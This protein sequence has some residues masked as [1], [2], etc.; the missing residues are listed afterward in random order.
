MPGGRRWVVACS[1]VVCIVA[2]GCSDP[3]RVILAGLSESDQAR[4][5]D[6]RQIAV[7]CWT[8]HDLAGVVK[9]VGPSLQGVYGRRSGLA[10][11]HGGS[12]AMISASIVWD[13][14][15]LAAF[16]RDPAGFVPGNR[17]V[18]PGIRDV[19][20]LSDLLFYLRHVSHPGARGM[21][22]SH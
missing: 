8:C 1:L 9:K 21:S 16:L 14:R 22:A 2:G 18:S 20:S 12:P 3:D 13:D 19:K 4:F 15:S 10:P 5:R 17:M 7:P 6:G 11:G